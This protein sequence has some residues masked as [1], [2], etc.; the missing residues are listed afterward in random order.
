MN[1]YDLNRSRFCSLGWQLVVWLLISGFFV[2]CDDGT[3]S[4]RY[5]ERLA[6]VG[7][8]STLSFYLQ[9]SRIGVSDEAG[10]GT[11]V[12]LQLPLI[13]D[14]DRKQYSKSDDENRAQVPGIKIPGFN[15][16]L[17][18]L[19][20]NANSEFLP[21]QFYAFANSA[22]ALSEDDFKAAVTAAVD[23]TFGKGQYGWGTTNI[24]NMDG[25][26]TSWNKMEIL[27]GHPFHYL[28]ADQQEQTRAMDGKLLIY[29]RSN[30]KHTIAFAFR[31]PTELNDRLQQ[32]APGDSPSFERAI[33]ASLGSVRGL[34]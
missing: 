16:S 3:Y 4:S 32:P 8:I 20:G 30:G 26:T 25:S 17:E 5:K 18:R 14:K 12:D 23:Q 31:F 7:R 21:V 13:F 24:I 1:L 19:A 11:G 33:E 15:Y 6:D 2:G 29:E 34:K 27:A 28:A 10:K 22:A 9:P